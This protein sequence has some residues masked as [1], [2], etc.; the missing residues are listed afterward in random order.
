MRFAMLALL[1]FVTASTALGD[2]LFTQDVAKQG[3]L[4]S[5]KKSRFQ[6]GDI[7]TVL[8]RES[9][10]AQTDANTNTKKESD[11]QSTAD[12]DSNSFLVSPKPNGLGL[13][14]PEKLP[15]WQLETENEQRTT[16]QTKRTN[17]L[18]TTITC[19]VTGVQPNG[20]V[21]LQGEKTVTVNREDSR[22]FVKGIVRSRDVTPENT[23]D[24]TQIA[25][26]IVELKGKGPLWNNQ[27]R[28]LVT[29][30]LDWFSPY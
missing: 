26:A 28:G 20:N 29:R 17:R 30:F 1:G 3:T 25:N 8:V 11:V 19:T 21:E 23:V 2:S 14:D 5:M 27:R 6:K 15:N 10:E 9:I 12:A 18:I 16:G 13:L 24:S 4:V 22:I 7:I